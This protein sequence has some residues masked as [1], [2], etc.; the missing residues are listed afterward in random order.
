MIYDGLG[1]LATRLDRTETR[2]VAIDF[3]QRVDEIYSHL[4]GGEFIDNALRKEPR[5]L[6]RVAIRE[7]LDNALI[8]QDF[9]QSGNHVLV[10]V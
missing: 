8:H 10:I 3:E 7:L 5:M 2:G 4:P 1:K 6:P 9:D